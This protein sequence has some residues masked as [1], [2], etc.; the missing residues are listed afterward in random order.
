[1]PVARGRN[2]RYHT[3][4]NFVREAVGGH[5]YDGHSSLR[6]LVGSTP[7]ALQGVASEMATELLI[8]G[9]GAATVVASTLRSARPLSVSSTLL[10]LVCPPLACVGPP[11]AT[12][13]SHT[14]TLFFFHP[15][16]VDERR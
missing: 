15:S 2:V 10:G 4:M 3:L 9:A 6:R 7:Q 16:W 14:H 1:V 5:T 12:A 13:G 11:A 8:R